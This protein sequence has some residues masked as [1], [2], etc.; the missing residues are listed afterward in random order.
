MPKI[1]VIDT[2]FLNHL[3]E[4]NNHDNAFDLIVRFFDALN[5]KVLIHP[6]VHKH[7]KKPGANPLV[8]RLFAEGIVTVSDFLDAVV[9]DSIEKKQYEFVVRQVYRYFTGSDFPNID[10]FTQWK[11]NDDFGEV[12]SAAMCVTLGCDYLLSDDKKVIRHIGGITKRVAQKFIH[13]YDRKQCCDIVKESGLMNHKEL[14][15]LKHKAK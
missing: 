12:H 6:L 8:K 3:S 14:K 2:D 7:E 15:L 13:V 5:Y 11:K 9:N 1:A 4:L 10:L